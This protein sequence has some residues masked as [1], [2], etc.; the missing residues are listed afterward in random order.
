MTDELVNTA[1]TPERP[2]GALTNKKQVTL[3][4][5]RARVAKAAIERSSVDP[6][7]L[8]NRIP[9]MIDVSASMQGKPL[10]NLKDA[11]SSFLNHCN[12]KDTSVGLRSF[13]ERTLGNQQVTCDYS[14]L[15]ACV[16][17][18]HADDGTPMAE[19]MQDVL[20]SMPA[21]RCVLISDGAPNDRQ[22]CFDA[23]FLYKEAQIPIDCIHIG[24]S[25]S[26]ED[27]LARIAEIT[28]GKFIKFTDVAQLVGGLKYLTPAMYGMLT[29]GAVDASE[30]GAREI[31]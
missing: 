23:A 4:N 24:Y 27:V 25:S 1:G 3:T 30:I 8:A 17:G 10:E 6:T 14:Y 26:G 29:S 19:A 9:L 13:P 18:M 16:L 28:G 31:K 11:V 7:T 5:L 21:T 2:S 20:L 12:A 22:P 15:T